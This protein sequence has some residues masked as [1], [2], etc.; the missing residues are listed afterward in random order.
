MKTI[1][2]VF[3]AAALAASAALSVAAAPVN[4]IVNGD[5]E[6]GGAGNPPVGFE[7]DY[8]YRRIDCCAGSAIVGPH[9]SFAFSGRSS[10]N[11]RG[12]DHTTGSGDALFVNGS[13]NSTQVFW[14]QTVATTIGTTY[15]FS[16]WGMIWFGSNVTTELKVN[17]TSVGT[18][19]IDRFGTLDVW[20]QDFLSFT[21]DSTS[22]RL[23]LINVSTGFSGND[24]AVD[25][26]VLTAAGTTAVPGPLPAALLLS[27]LGGLAALRRRKT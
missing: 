16:A 15:D 14:R 25:D 21:A 22:S 6:T 12:G 10:A 20:A 27:G 26:L 13:T 24:F 1:A 3:C 7:T 11:G 17:G 9:I 5:F 2:F 18:Y 23:E 8:Q 19:V 4:L